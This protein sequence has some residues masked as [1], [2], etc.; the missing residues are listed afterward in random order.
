MTSNLEGAK[1]HLKEHGWVRIPSVLNKADAVHALDRLW[2]AKE[3]SEASGEETYQPILDPD[4]SNVRVF[5][6]LELD[7]LFR[8]MLT[9]P[10][11]IELTK[12]VLGEKFLLPKELQVTLNPELKGMLGLSHIGY[13]VYG[14][15]RYMDEKYPKKLEAKSPSTKEQPAELESFPQDYKPSSHISELP[16]NAQIEEILSVINRDGGVILNNLVSREELKA[17]EDELAPYTQTSKPEDS[18][19]FKGL[20]PQETLLIGGLVG[21]SPTLSTICEYPVLSHLRQSILTDHGVRKVECYDLPYH[22]ET[23]LSC[24]LSFRV[25]YGAAR[26]RLHRDDGTHLVEHGK[27]PYR[28][29]REAQLGVLI[30]GCETSQANGATMFVVGSHRWD[31]EREPK[32]TRLLSLE[33]Q[34]LAI[35]RSKVLGMSAEMQSLL[36][37]KQPTAALGMVE[38]G[39]PMDDVVGVIARANM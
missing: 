38:N 6:L 31:D 3:A 19:F 17:I 30:A 24:S 20:V 21:K 18:G 34:F 5:Y 15:L 22:I 13:H 16:A 7:K 8:D 33:N 23:L 29:D 26:Q 32:W 36:G 9:Y 37:Y 39:D 14:D 2:K 1:A 10:A 35:P 28:R 27:K 11:G 25:G 4:P 12:S